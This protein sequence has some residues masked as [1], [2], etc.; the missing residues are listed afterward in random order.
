MKL[1]DFLNSIKDKVSIDVVYDIGAWKGQW[2]KS[3]QDNCFPN[4]R[5][6]LFEANP[7]YKDDLAALGFTSFNTVLSNPGREYVEFFNGTNTGD[8]YYKENTGWYDQQS[9]IK[10][11]CTTLD[12]AIKQ[13]NLPAPN[14][15][16]I[17]TQGSELDILSGA[18]SI[19]DKVDL[20]YTECPIIQYNA[21]SPNIS[22]YLDYFKSKNFIP[23]DIFEVHN[24]EDTLLQVDIMFMKKETK[25]RVFGPNINIRPFA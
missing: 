2:S 1:H 9:S 7:A 23:L 21:G 24:M 14:F 25:E 16:K 15:I 12:Y 8:S 11:P 19:I 13:F 6:F 22:A 18:E 17:D 5:Y 20:I 3:L 4:A 10:L